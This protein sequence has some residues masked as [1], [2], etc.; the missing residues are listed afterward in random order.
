[1]GKITALIA[2]DSDAFAHRILTMLTKLS[3]VEIVRRVSNVPEA[4]EAIRA[5]KPD[6]VI[7]DISMPGGSGIDVLEG[8]K[9]NRQTSI[10]IVFTNYGYPQYRKKCLELGARYFFDKV[11]LENVSELL[12]GLIC[13][14][15][16]N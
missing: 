5:L 4:A 1:V 16:N 15:F 6:V 8:M 13:D 7:L 3:G 10:V 14:S 2:E 12:R 9:K 11:E